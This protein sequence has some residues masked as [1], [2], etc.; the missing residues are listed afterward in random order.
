MAIRVDGFDI[1]SDDLRAFLRDDAD[2]SRTHALVRQLV[3]RC[4][5]MQAQTAK[6]TD[7]Q[8]ADRCAQ[9]AEALMNAAT[10]VE[11]LAPRLRR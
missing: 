6:H 8:A 9:A 10:I 1:A 11:R 7:P 3:A 5:E 2:G 4:S